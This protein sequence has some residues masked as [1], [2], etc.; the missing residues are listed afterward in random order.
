MPHISSHQ[1]TAFKAV[2]VLHIPPL[3][4]LFRLSL[5]RSRQPFSLIIIVSLYSIPCHSSFAREIEVSFAYFYFWASEE[6]F[7]NQ[8]SSQTM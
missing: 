1:L 2:F 5:L 8:S 3:Q 6:W 4:G 7:Q